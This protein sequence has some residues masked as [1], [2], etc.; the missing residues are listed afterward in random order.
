MADSMLQKEW[1][2]NA[3]N[4][5]IQ[6]S[7]VA[8]LRNKQQ[9]SP[10]CRRCDYISYSLVFHNWEAQVTELRLQIL[11]FPSSEGFV[12]VIFLQTTSFF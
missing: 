6:K 12:F 11:C 10:A 9:F 5:S 4:W 3:A 8:Q 2:A 7:G 1:L